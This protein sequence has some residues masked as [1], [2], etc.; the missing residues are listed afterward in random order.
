MHT[1]ALLAALHGDGDGR[2]GQVDGR[3]EYDGPEDGEAPYVAEVVQ[4]PAVVVCQVSRFKRQ[5]RERRRFVVGWRIIGC[6]LAHFFFPIPSVRVAGANKCVLVS[7]YQK[8]LRIGRM[9]IGSDGDGRAG[10]VLR[11][12][13]TR[14]LGSRNY[15]RE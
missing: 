6:C 10:L 1:R 4:A 5:G 12:P 9:L 7:P 13:V 14:N 8:R 11:V 15:R 3:I 2:G